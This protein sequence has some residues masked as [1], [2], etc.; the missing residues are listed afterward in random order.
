M[1]FCFL[2]HTFVSEIPKREKATSTSSSRV[3]KNF[4][5]LT[6]GEKIV[7]QLRHSPPLTILLHFVTNTSSVFAATSIILLRNEQRQNTKH[8]L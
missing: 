1:P 5:V 6:V 3:A 7:L 4:M 8:H 2:F